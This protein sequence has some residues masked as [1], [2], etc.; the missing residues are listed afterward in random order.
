MA[1]S[2]RIMAR[3]GMMPID[4]MTA[5]YRDQLYE[6]YEQRVAEDG[7]TLYYVPKPGAERIRV[8]VNTRLAAAV[9]AARYVHRPMPVGIEVGGRNEVGLTLERLRALS[10]EELD[11]ALRLLDKLGVG[12]TVTDGLAPGAT[13]NAGGRLLSAPS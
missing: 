6:D 1:A 11:G 2:V 4:F 5:V 9:S 3:T 7:R 10:G 8:D 13:T 12:V